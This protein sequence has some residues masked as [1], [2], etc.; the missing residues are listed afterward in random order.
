MAQI[1]DGSGPR[2][3][4]EGLTIPLQSPNP[5]LVRSKLGLYYERM[6]DGSNSLLPN[7]VKMDELTD[8]K[9]YVGIYAAD[10]KIPYSD[11]LPFSLN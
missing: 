4:S 10:E 3:G 9:V 2:F 6:P 8:L 5:R 1:D 11:A 7:N